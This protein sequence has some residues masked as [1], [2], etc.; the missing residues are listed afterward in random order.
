MVMKNDLSVLLNMTKEE[1]KEKILSLNLSND[2][3]KI[4]NKV[5]K[6]L[7]DLYDLD[8]NESKEKISKDIVIYMLFKQKGGK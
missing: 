4:F 6:A 2:E 7:D 8:N 1:L 3:Q 5:V